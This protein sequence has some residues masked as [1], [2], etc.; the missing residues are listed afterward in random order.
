MTDQSVTPAAVTRSGSRLLSKL[1]PV[2]VT[3]RGKWLQCNHFS[4]AVTPLVVFRTGS[5][6]MRLCP[7][8]AKWE[9][10]GYV[11]EWWRLMGQ[12]AVCGIH[13]FA[14]RPCWQPTAPCPNGWLVD[15][16]GG[17]IICSL[18]CTKKF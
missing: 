2:P 4:K 7:T 17:K 11:G 8:C 16:Y 18:A 9:F 5:Y 13:V 3:G 6:S 1:D 15:R 14:T 12:C 10:K